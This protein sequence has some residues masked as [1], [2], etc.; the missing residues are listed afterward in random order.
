MVTRLPTSL[1]A[2]IDALRLVPLLVFPSATSRYVLYPCLCF[3]RLQAGTSCTLA[4]VSFGYKQVES[5]TSIAAHKEGYN[6]KVV[7]V[8]L[9][10][11]RVSVLQPQKARSTVLLH[12]N[13]STKQLFMR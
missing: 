1:C 7:E 3:L 13:D 11:N 5:S 6:K 12:V 8:R 9:S 2:A 4:C 10:M